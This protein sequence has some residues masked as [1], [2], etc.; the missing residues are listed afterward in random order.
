MELGYFIAPNAQVL[1]AY[2][3]FLIFFFFFKAMKERMS[4][5]AQSLGMPQGLGEGLK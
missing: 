5:I 1:F 2:W 4:K 3:K